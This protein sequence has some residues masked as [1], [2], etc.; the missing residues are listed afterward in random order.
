MT[1]NLAR[2]VEFHATVVNRPMLSDMD[3]NMLLCGTSTKK[4]T[5][6]PNVT[7]HLLPA[8]EH[9]LKAATQNARLS[10]LKNMKKMLA[11]EMISQLADNPI[12]VT[13]TAKEGVALFNRVTMGLTGATHEEVFAPFRNEKR[14][15]EAENRK[16]N[17]S[18]RKA[19]ELIQA[20]TPE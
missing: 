20:I 2:K 12:V 9:V 3:R 14:M 19:S 1:W 13:S 10:S 18:L 7:S 16:H 8:S 11:S 6:A 17:A 4:E 5:E 15:R